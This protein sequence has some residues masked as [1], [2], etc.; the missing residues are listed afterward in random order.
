MAHCTVCGTECECFEVISGGQ[1]YFFDRV[2]CAVQAL[3]SQ[4]VHCGERIYGDAVELNGQSYCS[5]QCAYVRDEVVEVEVPVGRSR[6]GRNA[7]P[8][9]QM[10]HN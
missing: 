6:A 9:L 4:C 2:D 7:I 8:T 5:A 10:Q 3:S 1:H